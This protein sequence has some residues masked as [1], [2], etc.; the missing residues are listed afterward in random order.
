MM[1]RRNFPNVEVF[2]RLRDEISRDKLVNAG[3]TVMLP[4]NLEPSLQLASSALKA[5]GAPLDEISQVI[6]AFRKSYTTQD[7]DKES[8]AKQ[9][10][11]S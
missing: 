4:E 3:A 6:D 5:V 2:V 7:S 11:A 8:L 9:S 10:Q 1:M